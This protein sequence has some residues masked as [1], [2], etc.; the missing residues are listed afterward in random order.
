MA[1]G[2]ALALGDHFLEAADVL[3]VDSVGAPQQAAL[4]AVF[5]LGVSTS[6]GAAGRSRATRRA[7]EPLA[8]NTMIPAIGTVSAIEALALARA[9]AVV[10][11]GSISMKWM[12]RR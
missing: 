6:I 10:A 5:W 8:V 11:S 2:H 1:Q 3:G 12:R 7:V 4:R 9:S